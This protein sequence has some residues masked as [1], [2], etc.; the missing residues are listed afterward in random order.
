MLEQEECPEFI[1]LVDALCKTAKKI[2]GDDGY[3][4]DPKEHLVRI[5]DAFED[6]RNTAIR[7]ATLA[8]RASGYAGQIYLA[9]EHC[10]YC[11]NYIGMKHTDTCVLGAAEEMFSV[12]TREL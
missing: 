12:L 7:L 3:W 5:E 8:V 1:E 6:A 2:I 4:Q 9:N 10:S 11:G